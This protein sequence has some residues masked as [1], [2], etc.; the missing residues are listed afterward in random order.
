LEVRNDLGLVLL[1]DLGHQGL[2]ERDLGH[3][4]L[5]T[6]FSSLLVGDLGDEGVSLGAVLT[7]GVMI[8]SEIYTLL[9]RVLL[10]R[11]NQKR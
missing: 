10:P 3:R 9:A 2:V 7:L 11:K 5:K 8:Y 4:D 6:Y 1:A